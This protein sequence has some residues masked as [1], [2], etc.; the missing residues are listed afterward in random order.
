MKNE[1]KKNNGYTYC[2][3]DI[4]ANYTTFLE[5]LDNIDFSAKDRLY[6]LG[7][8]LDNGPEPHLMAK[9]LIKNANKGNNITFI[10]G[11]H[12]D[13]MLQSINNDYEKL[14]PLNL[15][16][17][18]ISSR[19]RGWRTRKKILENLNISER[20]QLLELLLSAP[21]M[22]KIKVK[23]KEYLLSHA[24]PVPPIVNEKNNW[25]TQ[26]RHSLLWG[27]V[28]W[29]TYEET[30]PL[31][32]E[33]GFKDSD[34]SFSGKSFVAGNNDRVDI[35]SVLVPIEE[36]NNHIPIDINKQLSI[37]NEEKVK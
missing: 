6:I 3:S 1:I 18:W 31:I 13:A 16:D 14:M 25:L 12:E 5:L 15:S 4:H 21:I 29:L 9:W 19:M 22:L 23:D 36:V 26:E 8:V 37:N 7:D 33:R 24:G 11:N 30:L 34:N 35:K 2:I 32:F 28:E 10:L 17:I 20:K 27:S